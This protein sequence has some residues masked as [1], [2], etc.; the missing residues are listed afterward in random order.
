MIHAQILARSDEKQRQQ[1]DKIGT[2]KL[3]PV[4]QYH[5]AA[6]LRQPLVIAVF[7]Q[8]VFCAIQ[9]LDGACGSFCSEHA[10]S[11]AMANHPYCQ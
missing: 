4:V 11:S 5:E 1:H 9:A 2:R 10:A 6:V 8:N 3:D 7:L